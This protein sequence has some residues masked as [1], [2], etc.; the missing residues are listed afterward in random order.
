LSHRSSIH[1]PVYN[2]CLSSHTECYNA[3]KSS[4]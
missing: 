1:L 3:K 4:R 2:Y